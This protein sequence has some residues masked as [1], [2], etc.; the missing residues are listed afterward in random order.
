[1]GLT[2]RLLGPFE[3]D[4]DGAAARA[5]G[6]PGVLLAVLAMSAGHVVSPDRLAEAAWAGDVAGAPRSRVQTNITR[7]R[8]LIGADAVQT[9]SAGYSLRAGSGQ[10]DALRFLELAD[11]AVA[12]PAE[13]TEHELLT[14]ALGLW[15]GEP[16]QGL[17]SA[18]LAE[19]QAP[20]LTERY[21]TA[22]ER[23]AELTIAAGQPELAVAG[24]R[25]LVSSHPLRES[26]WARLLSA[27]GQAGRQA[28][29]LE[30]Y[31]T[32]RRRLA[33]ELGVDPGP[34]L[35]AL[36]AKLLATRPIPPVEAEPALTGPVESQRVVP[37][38]LPPDVPGFAGREKVLATMDS[39][40]GD[41]SSPM[42]ITTLGGPAGVGKTTLAVHW[43]HRVTHW[44]PDG[45][46]YANLRG[47]D[48][49]GA[50]RDAEEV[51]RGFLGALSVEPGQIPAGLEAKAGLYRS[52][53]A[54]RRVLVVLDNARDA[55]QVRP[56]LP[57]AP[58]SHV[59]ITSRDALTG[60]IVAEGAHPV[61]LDLLSQDEG[62][63]LLE[64]R[65]GRQRVA[66]DPAATERVLERCAG[67]PLALAVVAARAVQQ[68]SAPMSELAAG[69]AGSQTGLGAFAHNDPMTDVR[70]V[71]SWSYHTLSPAAG[72][73]FRLLSLHPGPDLSVT[74]AASIAGVPPGAARRS[75]I[76]LTDAHLLTQTG[77]RYAFHDLLCAYSGELAETAD[78]V[79]ERDQAHQRMLDHY[80]HTAHAAAN[81]IDPYRAP[82]PLDPVLPG[83]TLDQL[84]AEPGEAGDHA[85]AVAWFAAERLGLVAAVQLAARAGLDRHAWRLAWACTGYLDMSG[86]WPDRI[87]LMKATLGIVPLDPA[88]P[89]P[90]VAH[91]SLGHAYTRMGQLD[92]A[93]THLAE[94][95][96]LFRA[97]GDLAGQARAHLNIGIVLDRQGRHAEGLAVSQAAYELYLAAG[98]EAG[99]ADALN[100]LGWDSAQQGDFAAALSYCERSL[101][102]HQR[103][104]HRHGQADVWDSLGYIHRNLGHHDEAIACYQQAI[105]LFQSLGDRF[106]EA[107]TLANLGD[108]YEAAGD[109]T[110]ARDAWQRAH[111]ILTA[112]RH[113]SATR[114]EVKLAC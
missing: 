52:L 104:D 96:E 45:Q 34:P 27:L 90:A 110:Q 65:L 48:P 88:W 49:S 72:R 17:D 70:A 95:I 105:R 108:A 8:R 94:A 10:I 111:A 68:G 24:L 51:L 37:R 29:A 74:A 113:P 112:L 82:I 109:T 84:G 35:R 77:G 103:L 38:Q 46:L 66:A 75:L 78:P 73:L 2:V 21:L 5:T 91:R 6:R 7:L 100:A 114:L 47:F 12:T 33:S 3:V 16:F 83:V 98:H 85:G 55:G 64:H 53:L 44:F 97:S 36:H 57:S 22:V 11:L 41:G 89:W 69:L 13:E 81:I 62:W 86:Y 15:R 76:E 26:L 40:L 30:H 60:L 23:H 67:L 54:G 39:R 43:A 80:L 1:V 59:V 9:H 61:V 18:W 93:H 102:I 42:G 14:Q 19:T 28:E 25:P 50:P 106:D 56:L 31:E 92:Q 101:T 58:G 63:Q 71:F 32:I 20:R 107:G 4:V 79:R 87:R 99:Q